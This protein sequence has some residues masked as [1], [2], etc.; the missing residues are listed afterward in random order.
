[1]VLR[2]SLPSDVR[3]LVCVLLH[4]SG[5]SVSEIAIGAG[6]DKSNLS[7]FVRRSDSPGF[8]SPK[9]AS[10]LA[11]MGWGVSGPL[12]RIHFWYINDLQDAEWMFRDV[13]AGTVELTAV[14]ERQVDAQ[15]VAAE[16]RIVL[17]K[18]GGALFVLKQAF[19]SK[20]LKTVVAEDVLVRLITPQSRMAVVLPYVVVADSALCAR[21]RAE[22]VNQEELRGILEGRVSA[23]PDNIATRFADHR[24]AWLGDD[25]AT[26]LLLDAETR[27]ARADPNKM[28][29]MLVEA[30]SLEH[31]RSEGRRPSAKR[32]KELGAIAADQVAKAA[33]RPYFL[34][35]S[36]LT[37]AEN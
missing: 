34:T 4:W 14:Y 6:V 27:Q 21:I 36:L 35:W 23:L 11:E 25:Q 15:R 29:S 33:I 7:R 17:G 12:S 26:L 30:W 37:Q 3:R 20:D 32:E 13:L 16:D 10:L 9:V 18:L 24:A 28:A 19:F 22:T 8:S 2:A 1:M 31:V 5:R